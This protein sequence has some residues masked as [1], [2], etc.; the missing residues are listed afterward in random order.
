MQDYLAQVLR[1][2]CRRTGCFS[3]FPGGAL[4]FANGNDGV[5]YTGITESSKTTLPVY[6]LKD[7][8]SRQE[9]N[10]SNTPLRKHP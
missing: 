3:A 6:L 9:V 5:K 8:A 7:L 1:L 2:D 10:Q 4:S